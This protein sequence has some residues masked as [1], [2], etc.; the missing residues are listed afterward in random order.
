MQPKTSAL[1]GLVLAA[2]AC[3]PVPDPGAEGCRPG[4]YQGL[5]GAPLAAVTLP[6]GA[7]IRVIQPGDMVTQDFRPGRT[8]I[9]VDESGIITR[10]YCG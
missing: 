5:V 2:M 10:V 3:T 4:D 9:E 6:A 8:N 7:D 1:M